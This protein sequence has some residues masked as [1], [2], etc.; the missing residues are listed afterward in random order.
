MFSK[1][2]TSPASI[3]HEIELHA[4]PY[5]TTK[6][7]AKLPTSLQFSNMNGKLISYYHTFNCSRDTK[8][9]KIIG[10]LF[11]QN[12]I[13]N[14]IQEIRIN[15]EQNSSTELKETYNASGFRNTPKLVNIIE[16]YTNTTHNYISKNNPECSYKNNNQMFKSL[17]HVI[18]DD[19]S[20]ID[21]K[22]LVSICY[23]FAKLLCK[24]IIHLES[25]LCNIFM[26]GGF[27]YGKN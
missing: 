19:L 20:N 23:F 10:G 3:N 22:N 18:D 7:T 25:I 21:V 17:S 6:P 2:K 5:N 4:E 24:M 11:T 26:Y 14:S 13:N 1:S 12:K 27:P 15:F 16:K 8:A 9:R